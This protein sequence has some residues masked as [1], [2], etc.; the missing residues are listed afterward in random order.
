MPYYENLHIVK[1]AGKNA[2]WLVRHIVRNY[3]RPEI[4]AQLALS[5]QPLWELFPPVYRIA[6]LVLTE[7][8]KVMVAEEEYVDKDFLDEY[9]AF[10]CKGFA[11]P[12]PRCVRLHFFATEK[13]ST[14]ELFDLE[15]YDENYLGYT[16]VRPIEAFITGR[17]II[18][19]RFRDGSRHFILSTAEFE[20]NLSGSKLRVTG[21][22][23]MQQDNNVGVCAQAALW[24]VLLY[25]HRR[26]GLSRWLPSGI[27]ECATRYLSHGWPKV[28]LSPEQLVEVLRSAGLNP[29]VI[30]TP[31]TFSARDKAKL[32]YN[33]VESE[34]PVILFLRVV[35]GLHA[36]VAI[37]HT[38][39]HRLSGI[40][41]HHFAHNIDWIRNFYIHDDS[42]GPYQLMPVLHSPSGPYSVEKN[43]VGVLVPLDSG[44]RLRGDY[45]EG[46]AKW[47][48][49]R[50]NNLFRLLTAIGPHNFDE[51]CFTEEELSGLVLRAY[52]RHS[53]VYKEALLHC[54]DMDFALRKEYRS[55]R[56]PKYIWVVEI[57]REELLR[58]PRAELRQ[59]IGEVLL[60]PTAS[61]QAP[62]ASMLFLHLYDVLVSV[63]IETGPVRYVVR[64]LS[65]GTPYR[66]AI[67]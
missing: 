49:A 1:T 13:I 16:I 14:E 8:C 31:D 38:F 22:P 5:H 29:L 34:I 41:E 47:W 30:E 28:G 24:M 51:F 4:R 18:Q 26:H 46:H 15:R 45:A 42:R 7:G 67:R 23:F 10:Y 44:I 56:L 62:I 2:E 59:M 20:S 52:L 61:E 55:R 53:N 65:T 40:C 9:A 35:G 27:T 6:E 33:Y 37:G 66:H 39:D 64:R 63:R 32:I 21:M 43:V 54:A 3:C 25:C 57:S 19:R 12:A 11:S 36:V 60:D 48:I 58:K 17:T 50:I